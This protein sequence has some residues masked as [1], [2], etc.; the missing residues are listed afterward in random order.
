SWQPW[1]GGWAGLLRARRAGSVP[2]RNGS[3]R[4]LDA[5]ARQAFVQAAT[6]HELGWPEN[7]GSSHLAP[8]SHHWGSLAESRSLFF[9]FGLKISHRLGIRLRT[10]DLFRVLITKAALV[11]QTAIRVQR[12][13]A[14][15]IP[16]L[17]HDLQVTDRPKL[18]LTDPYVRGQNVIWSILLQAL[19]QIR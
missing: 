5:H 10:V 2:H 13:I 15:S 8:E 9:Q 3:G 6:R 14:H 12:A 19:F 4:G 1:P 7:T 18:P 17:N 11:Q 16:L